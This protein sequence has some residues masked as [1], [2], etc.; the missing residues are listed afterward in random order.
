MS[1]FHFYAAEH[2]NGVKEATPGITSSD[3]QKAMTALWRDLGYDQRKP[4]VS[5]AVED[6]KRYEEESVGYVPPP[7]PTKSGKR[8]AKD[9]EAPKKA[10]TAYLFFADAKRP[11]ITRKHP[12]VGVSGL[13][14]HLAEAWKTCTPKE[15]G[16]Y[17]GLAETDR[18]RYKTEM[19]NYTPSEAYLQAKKD[20]KKAKKIKAAGGEVSLDLPMA[21][22]DQTELSKMD[23]ENKA[24]KM[25]VAELE[26]QI[27]KQ[28][29]AIE[30]LQEK[31]DKKV[32]VLSGVRILPRRRR[33]THRRAAHRRARP[34]ARSWPRRRRKTR[35]RRRARCP[36]WRPPRRK[37]RLTT[38][39][40]GS[41]ERAAAQRRRP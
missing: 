19:E 34:R 23:E 26:K 38:S 30:K 24:L 6:K 21:L 40:A 13:A 5:M 16:K 41:G 18:E 27:I 36:R 8:L 28:A 37:S 7:K 10:K 3:I 22:F 32:R 17:E 29:A 15:R 9:A 11:E 31:S 33:A 1:A 39:R 2:R 12:G 14:K 25:Q 4:F 35:R 20:F